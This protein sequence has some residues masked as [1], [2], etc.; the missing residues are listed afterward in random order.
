MKIREA[1]EKRRRKE[2]LAL[3]HPWLQAPWDRFCKWREDKS[4]FTCCKTR[5]P[6]AAVP[7]LSPALCMLSLQLCPVEEKLAHKLAG[8]KENWLKLFWK[9]MQKPSNLIITLFLPGRCELEVF[10]EEKRRDGLAAAGE[11]GWDR[12]ELLSSANLTCYRPVFFTQACPRALD[13]PL[14]TFFSLPALICILLLWSYIGET[15]PLCVGAAG[16]GSVPLGGKGKSS[17]GFSLAAGAGSPAM[18]SALALQS[19]VFAKPC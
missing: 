3:L 14:R 8:K 11:A 4:V 13:H 1:K 16:G 12:P 19:E 7:T 15:N 2:L 18:L 10:N 17:H 5:S 9:C 6:A